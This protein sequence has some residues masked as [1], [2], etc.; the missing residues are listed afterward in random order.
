[1]ANQRPCSDNK[2]AGIQCD[3]D[4]IAKPRISGGEF[5]E[6]NGRVIWKTGVLIREVIWLY[7]PGLEEV[8]NGG[9]RLGGGGERIAGGLCYRGGLVNVRSRGRGLE[10][11]GFE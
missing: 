4:T 10:T 1:L 11:E 3:A 6:R 7:S 5:G 2:T 8:E 9:R